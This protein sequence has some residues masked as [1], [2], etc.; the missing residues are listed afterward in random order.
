M[1][2][3]FVM[4]TPEDGL[5]LL[6]NAVRSCLGGQWFGLRK[7]LPMYVAERIATRLCASGKLK[8][9]FLIL[10][11]LMCSSL[12]CDIF[13]RRM[14]LIFRWMKELSFRKWCSF[15]AQFSQPHRRMFTM[16]WTKTWCLNFSSTNWFWKKWRSL[17]ISLLAFVILL[18][19]S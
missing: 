10:V 1:A 18:L 5:G 9:I 16:Y 11:F 14:L 3:L 12:T 19:M 13:I 17:P 6:E 15:I 7:T 8:N 2:F 4:M